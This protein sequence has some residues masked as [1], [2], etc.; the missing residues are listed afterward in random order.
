MIVP[1]WITRVSTWLALS[2]PSSHVI[3]STPPFCHAD[4]ARILGTVCD[5]HLSAVCVEQS[6]P[7][8]HRSGVIQTKLGTVPA[9]S[10]SN[11]EKGTTWAGQ[12]L[13]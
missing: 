3:S 7:S 13:P 1:G 9:M 12:A 10:W 2:S 8:W 11:G 4:V 6:W 5:S